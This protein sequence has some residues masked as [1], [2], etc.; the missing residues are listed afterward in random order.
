LQ[1]GN[2][3]LYADNVYLKGSIQLESNEGTSA[4][5]DTNSLIDI[6]TATNHIFFD[7]NGNEINGK[8]VFFG[9]KN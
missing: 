1:N 8:V 7:E 2:Y 9:K 5:I 4:G 6:K 3:G